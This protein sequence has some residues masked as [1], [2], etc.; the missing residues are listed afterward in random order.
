MHVLPTQGLWLIPF[1]LMQADVCMNQAQILKDGAED[2]ICDKCLSERAE[3]FQA[4]GE[5]CLKCWQVMTYPD[6]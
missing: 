2:E 1:P 4:T 5:Y 3:L 6:L